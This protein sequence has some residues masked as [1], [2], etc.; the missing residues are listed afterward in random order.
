[1][2]KENKD[3]VVLA[4]NTEKDKDIRFHSR[5]AG[6][7]TMLLLKLTVTCIYRFTSSYKT[8]WNYSVSGKTFTAES[9]SQV[10][11]LLHEFL[12]KNPSASDTLG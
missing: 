11:A 5:T 9:K 4:C 2:F 8:L 3:D 7:F 10:Y 12:R 1:M 6:K